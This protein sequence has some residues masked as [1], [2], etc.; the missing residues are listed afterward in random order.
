MLFLIGA[1]LRDLGFAA[2]A[3]GTAVALLIWLEPYRMARI[4][5]WRNAWEDPYGDGYQLVNSE[6]AIGSGTWFGVGLGQGAQKLHY[7]PEAHTDFVFAVL[8]EEAGLIGATLVIV[9]FGIL[10]CRAYDIGRRAF[11]N[12]LP[13]H[14]LLAIAIGVSIGLQAAISIGVNSGVLPTK[15]LTLPLISFGRTSVVATLFALGLLFRVAVE[16]ERAGI[17]RRKGARK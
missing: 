9:L 11:S 4:A 2:A 17:P 12:G 8:A 3:S 7:L 15:G 10:V 14:G 6:I 1:R 5:S 16:V 13:F